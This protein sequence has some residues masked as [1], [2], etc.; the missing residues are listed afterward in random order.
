MSSNGTNKITCGAICH[1]K[2]IKGCS[3]VCVSYGCTPIFMLLVC[4]RVYACV[5]VLCVCVHAC[6][7]CVC[8]CACVWCS[9]SAMLSS[10]KNKG[11]MSS[12]D[13]VRYM[14]GLQDSRNIV[15]D[16]SRY[17]SMSTYDVPSKGQSFKCKGT[18]SLSSFLPP[19]AHNCFQ[20]LIMNNMC[21][22]PKI[23]WVV[24][25]TDLF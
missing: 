25:G 20:G 6:V 23:L 5:C 14:E 10:N 4:V 22:L 16:P 18:I 9:P 8:V 21:V 7:C 2:L 13:F 24:G 11:G 3:V 1:T 17:V 15:A 19:P 12:D